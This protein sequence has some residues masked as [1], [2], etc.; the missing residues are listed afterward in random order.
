MLLSFNLLS[1][2]SIQI[3]PYSEIEKRYLYVNKAYKYDRFDNEFKHW[4]IDDI[5]RIQRNYN[6]SLRRA[7]KNIKALSNL[8]KFDYFVTITF[9]QVYV[10]RKS[11]CDVHNLFK[12]VIKRLGYHFDSVEYLA[13]PEFHQDE[14]I[15]YHL[16]MN[17]GRRPKLF[18][19]G[20]TR[21]GQPY[22]ILAKSER[23]SIKL[24]DCFLTFEKI[25]GEQ[26][27]HYLIK[28]MTKSLGKPLQRRFMCSRGLK[29]VH[30]VSTCRVEI[31]EPHFKKIAEDLTEFKQF[32]YASCPNYRFTSTVRENEGA[33]SAPD[34]SINNIKGENISPTLVTRYYEILDKLLEYGKLVVKQPKVEENLP[35]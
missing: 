2:N 27:V 26:P 22:Y 1:D 13:V 12:L 4:D 32:G 29:R 11:A 7:I 8:N 21:K 23:E 15:H 19:K 31:C 33:R 17:F 18:Y 16:F 9:N 20:K 25:D 3:S 6:A 35:F 24:D 30:R 28:Y 14:A 10:N 5:S 34:S